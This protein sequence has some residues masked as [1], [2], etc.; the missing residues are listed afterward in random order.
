V[1]ADIILGSARH[2]PH[3]NLA[4]SPLGSWRRSKFVR[5]CWRAD[6]ARLGKLEIRPPPP[7]ANQ[8][9]E[10]L[11]LPFF[12]PGAWPHRGDPVRRSR[13]DELAGSVR[14]AA[15][16]SAGRHPGAADRVSGRLVLLIGLLAALLLL[17]GLLAACCCW[18]GFW[19]RPAC[20]LRT[21]L[22]RLLT[23]ILRFIADRFREALAEMLWRD[24]RIGHLTSMA[25]YCRY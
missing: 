10:L 6:R 21:G 22:I 24:S 17:V 19:R 20:W 15:P 5:V 3:H 23:R 11:E 12:S 25:S 9:G 16:A 4:H 13:S 14:P 2:F 1:H 18:S 8:K 7:G